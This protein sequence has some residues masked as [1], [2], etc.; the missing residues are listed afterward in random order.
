V[1]RD[2]VGHMTA[3]GTAGFLF[4]IALPRRRLEEGAHA[5]H[6][7][8]CFADLLFGLTR[9]GVSNARRLRDTVAKPAS[10]QIV[11]ARGGFG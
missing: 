10:T 9:L 7:I 1:P 6:G 3:R 4:A 5:P 2:S 8:Q 11:P